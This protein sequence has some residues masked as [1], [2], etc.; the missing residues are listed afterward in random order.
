M[1]R[2]LS[3]AALCLFSAGSAWSLEAE[4]QR[5]ADRYRSL[6]EAN[7]A[8]DT[9]FERLWKIYAEAGESDVLIESAR[10]DFAKHPRLAVRLLIKAGLRPEAEKRLTEAVTSGDPL[11]A[12]MLAD[13]R[14]EDGDAKAAAGLLEQAVA[15]QPSPARWVRLGTLW[16]K[17]GEA[18][19]S[20]EAWENAVKLAPGDLALRS[21]LAE[22]AQ[23][24]GEIETASGHW[25][26]IAENGT[27]SERFSAWEKISQIN[28]AAGKVPEAIEAQQALLGL[29]GPG[30]WKL[31]SARQRL[32]ALH[33]R[34]GTLA[35]LQQKWQE[36]AE[37]APNE[38][39]LNI[40][41]AE[42]AA[43]QGDPARRLQWLRKAAALLPK[44]LAL[45]GTV[46]SLELAQ[47]NFDEAAATYDRILARQP[48]H[49]DVVFLRAEVDVLAGREGPARERIESYVSTH[50]EDPN[51]S[52]RAEE[53]Y[54]R[55]RL[56]GP[57][58]EMLTAQF[59][60]RK[61]DE[62]AATSLARFYLEQA[63][64]EKAGE[65]LRALDVSKLTPAERAAVYAR[66]SD[67]LRDAG[68]PEAAEEFSRQALELAPANPQ[69]VLS[70][71]EMLTS[72]GQDNAAMNI[73]EKACAIRPDFL[74]R[75]D[76]DRRY[77]LQLQASK[78]EKK[79]TS[80]LDHGEGAVQQTVTLLEKQAEEQGTEND[81]LR[82]ARWLRW[83]D[84]AAGALSMAVQKYPDSVAL[85]E[86]LAAQLAEAGDVVA[87]IKEYGRLGELAPER[88]LEVQRK[89][90]HLE[91]DR[92][93]FDEALRIFETI[94]K[95]Q[96]KDWKSAADL[97]LAEQMAGNWYEALDT[98]RA[99][100]DLAPADAR[101]GL[102]Q[103]LLNATIR[104][105]LFAKGL[106]F[107]EEACLAEKDASMR[108]QLLQEAAAYAQENR[109]AG[110]WRTRLQRRAANQPAADQWKVG[111]ALLLAA[112][113]R[114]EES[115][116]LRGSLAQNSEE[117]AEDVEKLLKAAESAADWKEA[118]R[119]AA[120]LASL[121]KT[122]DATLAMREAE[123]LERAG[124]FKEAGAAWSTV[125]ARFARS[126]Q[127][128]VAAADY[129]GRSGDE[130]QWEK[131][132]R[133]AARLGGSPP[134]ISL[135]LGRLAL[136]RGDKA[137]ALDD[138]ESVLKNTRPDLALH[139][140]SLP[141]PGVLA[142]RAPRSPTNAPIFQGKTPSDEE[143]EGCRLLAIQQAGQLLAQSPSR[144]KW[145]GQLPP[146]VEKVWALYFSGEI[147]RAFEQME[148]MLAEG[149][150]ESSR[151][152]IF[153]SLLIEQGDFKRLVQW[154]AADP[155]K[156]EK[157][158]DEVHAALTTM[159][160][161]GWKPQPEF[162]PGLLTSAP[163]LPAWHACRILAQ[164]GQTG[165]A[166]R[167]GEQVASRFPASQAD[168]A[169]L[170]I[171][172][173]HVGLGETAGAIRNLDHV[174]DTVI[175][176][177]TYAS[178][179]FMAL[180]ARWLL[181]PEDER[182]AF[183]EKTLAR[184]KGLRQ[185]HSE[186][187]AGALLAAL[188][189][190]NEKADALAAQLF[191]QPETEKVNW[192][193][194]VNEGGA[195]LE[196]WQ[197]PRLARAL[198]RND[199]KRDVALLT[200]TGENL[201][202]L[203][204]TMLIHSQLASATPQELPYFINEWLARGVSDEEL[205]QAFLRLQQNG[206]MDSAAA[207][208]A[209][210]CKRM[211]RNEIVAGALLNALP[212]PGLR[213]EGMA[214]YTKLQGDEYARTRRA[215]M[216]NAGMRM[217]QIYGQEGDIEKQMSILTQLRKE[218]SVNRIMLLQ[219]VDAMNRLG[220]HREALAELES[221][222]AFVSTMPGFALPAAQLLAGLGREREAL[223]ILERE[224][225]NSAS[226][227]R[228]MVAGKLRELS[229]ELGDASRRA[230]A[231]TLLTSL[232]LPWKR[233]QPASDEDWQKLVNELD[234]PGLSS[235]ERF[236]A[237]TKLLSGNPTLPDVFFDRELG[238]LQKIA[239]RNASLQPEFY[240]LRKTL[241]SQRG[242]SAQL[243][244]E[245][246]KEWDGGRGG[247]FAGEI[248]LQ[249]LFE[250]ERWNDAVA[251]LDGYLTDAHFNETAWEEV[252]RRL[253]A[254]GKSQEA[255]RVLTELSAR[256][257]GD[258]RRK[259]LLAEALEKSGSPE[260]ARELVA[261]LAQIVA[262][263][264]QKALDLARYE[265]A[266][267]QPRL[268]ARWLDKAG[269]DGRVGAVRAAVAR[270]L[271]K[272]GD[273]KA[274]REQLLLAM[275]NPE[276]VP[277]GALAEYY[278]DK[279]ETMDPTQNE[280][281][282]PPRQLHEFQLESLRRL[283][284]KGAA[285]RVLVWL[286]QVPRLLDDERGR[287]VFREVEATDWKTATQIWEVADSP[288]WDVKTAAAAFHLRKFQAAGAGATIKELARAHELHPGSF[289]IAQVYAKELLK[290][291]KA[292]AARKVLQDVI[293]SY[294]TVADRKAAREML[295]TMQAAPGLPKE[296]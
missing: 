92:G 28:E 73:L 6:L 254:A 112:E 74:P 267:G 124:R 174:I 159:L 170:V 90:G 140:D 283:A 63:R 108:E 118:A 287:A 70:R 228:P 41:L 83:T 252:G 93:N 52:G 123:F 280:F 146:G 38:P 236:R 80:L 47:G 45:A 103:P 54:R 279:L 153:A 79:S 248:L 206:R 262:L 115:R 247:S 40:R 169:W 107:Y 14:E 265:I 98:W 42:M 207:I 72:L 172:D 216:Q 165:L 243:E 192:R 105:Q 176:E 25:R 152:Q 10:T 65:S 101:K 81:W 210:L 199:L 4:S 46:A 35:A 99:A 104:L 183:A 116:R 179:F 33:A 51:V 275:A 178:S 285:G 163:A 289:A 50:G 238:R 94:R 230:A 21:K 194:L 227:D 15:A 273:R 147:D 258:L 288:L 85:Q 214:Y 59:S 224:A 226:P 144:E 145:L 162:L 274:A 24:A 208:Y 71:V 113:G 18:Q 129:F 215:M 251:L 57:L 182:A 203:S 67:F 213:Q 130:E 232:G 142:A 122:P 32:V 3:V 138:F 97:A 158:W 189:K 253:L 250:Q 89:I 234:R 196:E 197:L 149:E 43:F 11:A 160:E 233:E 88:N 219:H 77:F 110:E 155:G 37:R 9:A 191:T 141:L 240:V 17:A 58:E 119:L 201:H 131:L 257:E 106:D 62:A 114:D 95:E 177:P 117:S 296:G 294:A 136:E 292:A 249:Q 221:S 272:A 8:Q 84:N 128:L 100:Y 231:E 195:R 291:D 156:S 200:M 181:T 209:V 34:A 282:L 7:P 23:Q 102:R 49:A 2:R 244:Q 12:E 245:L 126:P 271:V 256:S 55:L 161:A 30:H 26:V 269:G 86:A 139:K 157:R 164:H 290:S 260:K 212:T 277:T 150:H 278:E 22:A 223:A 66:F 237:G 218:D 31:A 143:I 263:D 284:A 68:L 20:R 242:K 91:L 148:G 16:Q 36:E 187:L 204:E 180:R 69:Y 270:D 60:K 264:R 188:A 134:Q 173:W 293:A 27:P 193:E 132:Y 217:A 276:S 198:Y 125:A 175:P 211:P 239:K 82:L 133:A 184:L 1:K 235:E 166:C 167:L 13:L 53:F 96:S 151:S 76:L 241:A 109:V 48:D 127:A 268:A 266:I 87:A 190:D 135:R 225:Q 281:G 137:L 185:P 61:T 75:E 246:R 78:E 121:R 295:L 56:S 171:A 154:A 29:M 120:R 261:P 220:L 44:D 205:M 202:Q 19:K 259:L 255:R 64:F 5:L 168:T 111:L 39:E 229:A 186:A 286:A 222:A